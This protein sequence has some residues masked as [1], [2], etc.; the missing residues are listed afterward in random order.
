LLLECADPA[1]DYTTMSQKDIDNIKKSVND[2]FSK[3][4]EYASGAEAQINEA[5]ASVSSGV[6]KSLSFGLEKVADT[7]SRVQVLQIPCIQDP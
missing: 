1:A 3:A 5:T 7:K 2:G 4:Y 6:R